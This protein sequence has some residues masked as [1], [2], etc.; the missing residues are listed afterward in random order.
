[1]EVISVSGGAMF[2]TRVFIIRA[3][4]HFLHLRFLLSLE[5][6]VLELWKPNPQSALTIF[7]SILSLC[8][9][10]NGLSKGATY[11][12]Q[13]VESF[14]TPTTDIQAVRQLLLLDT[15]RSNLHVISTSISSEF[16]TREHKKEN[17]EMVK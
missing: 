9:I 4:I 2:L 8:N 16:A 7:Q 13:L 14:Q 3:P 5:L 12:S 17:S 11:K 10:L 6:Y 1:M 15:Q